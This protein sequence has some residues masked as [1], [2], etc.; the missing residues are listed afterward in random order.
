MYTSDIKYAGTD[1][2][3]SV[4]VIGDDGDTGS[5]D[6]LSS[7]NDFERAAVGSYFF[8]AP[9]VGRMK[10]LKVSLKPRGLGVDWHLSHM[11]VLNSATGEALVFPYGDWL[12]K[13]NSTVILLP[14]ASGDGVPRA[15]VDDQF[16][17]YQVMKVFLFVK[18][19][20]K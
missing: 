1:S 10:K 6:L 15:G 5:H 4:T 19:D 3:V 16:L 2:D 12:T 18:G 14:Q 9:N 20:A 8:T 17:D 7:A 13:A 11:E